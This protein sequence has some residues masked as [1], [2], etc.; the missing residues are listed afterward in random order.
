VKEDAVAAGLS[1][2][3]GR[4]WRTARRHGAWAA[5][6]QAFR[7]RHR[8]KGVR[9]ILLFG[10]A[11]PPDLSAAVPQRPIRFRF[12]SPD[13]FATLGGMGPAEAAQAVARGDRCLLQFEEARLVGYN[14]VAVA[15]V[16][17]IAEGLYLPLPDDVAYSWKAYTLPEFRG[18][19][20][21]A[22]RALELHRRLAAE[23]RPRLLCFV[24]DTNLESLRSVRKAGYEPVGEVRF[25]VGGPRYG[26]VVQLEREWWSTRDWWTA[27]R[28]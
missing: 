15:P 4:L 27:A 8:R 2:R 24:D 28:D 5:A 1:G 3:L 22:L 13:E 9:R 17:F 7:H 18:S 23:G 19:G 21:H 16:V 12:A 6:S 20:L 14:W 10:L 25:R 26:A 11:R